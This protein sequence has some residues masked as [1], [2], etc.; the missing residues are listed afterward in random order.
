MPQNTDTGR[1]YEKSNILHRFLDEKNQPETLKEFF[2]AESQFLEN[3]IPENSLILD[4]GCGWGRHLFLVSNKIK[5]GIGIDKDKTRI[6]ES[7]Q[8]LKDKKNIETFHAD[9]YKIPFPEDYFDIVICMNNTFGNLKE[10][11]LAL[12]EMIRVLK[13]KGKLIL[14]VHSDKMSQDKLDWYKKVG[15]KNPRFNGKFILTNE[16]FYSYCFKKEY[17]SALFQEFKNTSFTITNLTPY[18]YLCIIEKK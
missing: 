1:F 9:I 3:N 10:H 13:V 6:S 17:L 5:K 2:K 15:L 12:K 4:A 14:S 11:K 16:G 7:K 8:F 18:S